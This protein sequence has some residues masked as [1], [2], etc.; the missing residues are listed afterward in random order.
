MIYVQTP[1]RPGVVGLVG[2]EL[3]RYHA[4]TACF[5]ALHVPPRTEAYTGLGYDVGYNRNAV[6][7]R[8]K[9]EGPDHDWVQIWDDDHMFDADVLLRLLDHMYGEDG[10]TDTPIDVI[11]PL[12]AQRVPPC[13][14]CIFKQENE[15]GSFSIFLWRDLE[16]KDGAIPVVSAGAGGIVIKRKVVEALQD[17]WFER[18]GKVGED[19][20]FC[21]KAREAGFGVYAALDVPIDH[22]TTNI[23]RP[24]RDEQGRWCGAVDVGKNTVLQLWDA[25]YREATAA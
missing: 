2:G 11:V 12:Y 4:F 21:K 19:H 1:H 9:K 8:L 6:I 15:D 20:L 10:K 3:A 14:P 16:G 22:L 23:V 18:Q 17:P 7:E 5:T 13:H 24:H 25:K